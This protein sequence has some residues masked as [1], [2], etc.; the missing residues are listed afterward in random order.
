MK[1]DDLRIP[2][3]KI[4]QPIGEYYIGKI[5]AKDLC[6]ITYVDR[7]RIDEEKGN[8]SYLG[9]QR[10][11]SKSRVKQLSEYVNTIDACFPTGIILSIPG[12]CAQYDA[13][14]SELILFPYEKISEDYKDDILES[15]DYNSI[16]KVLDGQHRI[17]GLK[18]INEGVDFEMNVSLFIDIDIAD[19]AYIFSTVN[20]AQTKVNKSLAYDLYELARGRSPQKTCHNIAVALNKNDDSPFFRRIKRLGVATDGNFNETITQATMVQSLLRYISKEPEKDRDILLRGKKLSYVDRDTSEKLI[21]RNL[22]IEERDLDILDIIWN[23]FDAVEERWSKSWNATGRGKMLNK[24]NGFK[25][26]MRFLRPAYLYLCNP[27]EIP[28]TDDFLSIFK[29]INMKNPEYEK[30]FSIEEFRPG[31]SGESEFYRTLLKK[32]GLS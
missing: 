26:L 11:L 20:L 9:V 3:I 31:S 12:N 22:F 10:P 32:S 19:D 23:Y 25:G 4:K 30:M 16:A 5:K 7:R 24:T 15:I 6:D 18:N 27:S 28:T 17:E 8:D 2:C 21:F 13:K 1:N 14:K 29:K